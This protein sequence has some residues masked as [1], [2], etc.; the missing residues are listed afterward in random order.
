MKLNWKDRSSVVLPL[1]RF[2]AN[3]KWALTREQLERAKAVAAWGR[4]VSS[5][6]E[7]TME[8]VRERMETLLQVAEAIRSGE[9]IEGEQEGGPL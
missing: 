7:Q 3:N 5:D 6:A 1:L 4:D 2:I 8:E 9:A